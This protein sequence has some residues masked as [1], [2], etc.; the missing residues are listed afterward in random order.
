MRTPPHRHARMVAASPSPVDN[1]T[2]TFAGTDAD[3]L[4]TD[5][6]HRLIGRPAEIRGPD[7]DARRPDAHTGTDADADSHGRAYPDPDP[8]LSRPA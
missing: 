5:G 3:G 8:D 4:A 2:D 1:P 6:D 7:E